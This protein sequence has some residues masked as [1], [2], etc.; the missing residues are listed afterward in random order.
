MQIDLKHIAD[1]KFSIQLL[2]SGFVAT[3]CRQPKGS[4]LVPKL[5]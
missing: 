2:N 1:S 4:V 5:N 3:G